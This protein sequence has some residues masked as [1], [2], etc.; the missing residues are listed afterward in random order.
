MSGKEYAQDETESTCRTSALTCASEHVEPALAG[1]SYSMAQ[2]GT[3]TTQLQ[4][5]AQSV[6]MQVVSG[7]TKQHYALACSLCWPKSPTSILVFQQKLPGPQPTVDGCILLP[8]DVQVIVSL[9]QMPS[10]L[11]FPNG[12]ALPILH[13]DGAVDQIEGPSYPEDDLAT[14]ATKARHQMNARPRQ[15]CAHDW[16]C[17]QSRAKCLSCVQV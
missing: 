14:C 12:V 7:V 15:P 5:V 13:I 17:G 8:V 9:P 3:S 1:I 16:Q 2:A 4:G 11:N 10:L 6:A